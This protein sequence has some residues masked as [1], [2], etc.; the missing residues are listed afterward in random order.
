MAF[1]CINQGVFLFRILGELQMLLHWFQK[2]VE[3]E[4]L[5]QMKL[6]WVRTRLTT[7]PIIPLGLPGA[8][9]AAAAPLG[10]RDPL[11][12]TIEPLEEGALALRSAA[13]LSPFLSSFFLSS[14]FV[15]LSFFFPKMEVLQIGIRTTD[16]L[17]TNDWTYIMIRAPRPSRTLGCEDR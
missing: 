6:E 2:F 11:P 5:R 8:P 10:R 13:F 16:G 3:V 14:F 12:A 4:G 9:A 15:S 7:Y 17:M 1:Q